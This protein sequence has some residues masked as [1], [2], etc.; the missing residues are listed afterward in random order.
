MRFFTV[1]ILSGI[2]C[3]CCSQIARSA[4]IKVVDNNVFVETDTYQVEFTD[5]V[6]TQF[7]NKL[8][9]E[10]YTLPLGAGGVTGFRGRSGLLK[11]D[12]RS[13]WTD[14]ATLIEARK[15]APLKAEILFRQGQNRI[16]L[17]IG[18]DA[19][20]GDLLIQ[21]DGTSDTAGVYG[22]QWGCGNLNVRSLDLIL[23]A[24]GGQIINAISPFTSRSFD[25]PFSWE[26]QLA[27]LQG[28]QGGFFVRGTDET[29]R[30]KVLHYE[31]D[32]E[33][34]ALGFE[35][36]N[37]APF[38]ALTS[39]KSVVW[40]LNTYTGDW[41]VPARQY[42]EWMERT[43]KPWRLSDMPTWVQN[44]G[45]IVIYHGLDVG[46]LDGLA[47]QI[48]P[49]KTLLYVTGWRKN[50]YDVNYPDY[51]AKP[52]FGRFVEAARQYG[53]RVMPHANLVGVSPYHS[54]YEDLQQFQFRDPW[55]GDLRGWWW[56]RTNVPQRH[57]FINLA[58]SAFRKILI[59]QL[60]EVWEKYRVDAFHLDISHFVIND[61]NGLVEGLTPAQG[62]LR[63][64][65]ELAAAMPKVVF[66]GES[67]HEVTFF[68][69]SFAQRWKVSHRHDWY[70]GPAAKSHPISSFLFSQYTLPYGY[71]ALPNPDRGLQL[72]QEYLESYE[73]WGVLPTL[74]LSSIADL[75]PE[76][77][78]T[79]EL[80]SIARNWQQLGLKPDFEMDWGADTLFQYVGKGDEIATLKTTD[81]GSIFD[82][83]QEDAGYERVFGVTQVKT[84]RS[85]PHW[86]AY[87][88]TMILGLN[89]ER[90]YFLSN[91]PRNFSRVHINSLPVGVA[92]TESRV[93][94]NAA[95]FQLEKMDVRHDID[96]LSQ[97]H[98]L[99]T[100]IVVN[101]QELPRQKGATFGHGK[102]SIS[103]IRKATIWAQPPWQGISG[104]TF[105]EWTLSLP[106]SSHISLDFD[107][108]LA[109]GSENSDG[110]TF[111]VS[112][113]GDEIFRRHHTEQKWEH[114]RLDLTAYQSEDIKLR[115]TTNPGPE[116]NTGWDWAVWGE[117]KIVSEPSNELTKVG[118]FLPNEPIKTFPDTLEDEGNGQY[119]IETALPA[120]I[121]FFFQP[122]QQMISPYNLRDTEFTAGLQF[123]GIFRLGS[124]WNSGELSVMTIGGIPKE[125][126]I[127]HPP[128]GGQTV[129]QF[130]LF[131]P[132]ARK[133]IFSFSM[134]LQDGCSDGVFF[135]VLVNGETQ[136]E[137]FT[138][139]F[140]WEDANVS[141]SRYT[142]D[143]V[144]LEL[145]TDPGED[146]NCDWAQ[147]ADL[148]IAAEGVEPSGDVNQDGIVNILDIIL[149]AQ[150]LGQKLP[151]NP[152]VDVNKDGQVNILDL[153]S[154]AERLGKKIAAA[155]SLMDVIKNTPSSPEDVIVVRRALNELE[156]IPEKSDSVKMT[157]QIL[158]AWLAT[159][160]QGVRETRLLP[161]YPN[162]FNPETWIPYQL[163]D[164]AD[165]SM[166]IYDVG[167]RLVRTIPIGFKPVGYYLTRERAAYWDGRN[168]TGEQVSSGVYFLQ[169]VAG[170]FTATQRAVIVK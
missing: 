48:D 29:F 75:G 2:V 26:V 74:R 70:G 85:L 119:V 96:L 90:S 126:I 127:A 157:V 123:E 66:S 165:V 112:V 134:G 82:L 140:G 130:L 19:R 54:L 13:I 102:T 131:L 106:N 22:I 49:A 24:D 14:Q 98:V 152:R 154:V 105:G 38:D 12:G 169:F 80:L 129:L 79:Q 7:H 124:V 97:F 141:L 91:T 36:Q 17:F 11:R 18:V 107:I 155:P 160:N 33:S 128:R 42:R 16:R 161:N 60:K 34:F 78:R 59:R 117:P 99:K 145:I 94:E 32:V 150:N 133:I 113:Q 114:I 143:Y 101:G 52:E 84:D 138:N 167:G 76:R 57:A 163:A 43:F 55:N 9:E 1:V 132:Q 170:D 144:L 120:Q 95:L 146:V 149:V 67:L 168:E 10:T 158:R 5:G 159:A 108:G 6:I 69:E 87:N 47:E 20:S 58:N 46:I 56:E 4:E 118:F 162:P 142:G 53:F 81:G 21:Q 45:L 89:P 88:E 125:S 111:I 92:V 166:E 77:V 93:T 139:T 121:L 104:D 40:R 41:R 50:D 136:F 30:F 3:L 15:V 8:T 72:Y 64:H 137:R 39:A 156:T 62:N 103:G 25:Y 151:S 68:R 63:M 100:G 37:Q 116:E 35:T 31:K 23:A 71:L 135:K 148:F 109:E 122:G 27:I 147:W 28:E 115:F 83:P 51:T 73:N 110:V 44:I 164:A 65:E 61:A 153:V 86:H